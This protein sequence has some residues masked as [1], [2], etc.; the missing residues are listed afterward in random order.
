V[1]ENTTTDDISEASESGDPARGPFEDLAQFL[2]IPRVT[3]LALAPDGSRLVVGVQN[4]SADKKKFTSSIWQVDPDGGEPVRLTRSAAGESAP[5]FLPDGS[6]LFVAKRPDP[7]A[8]EGDKEDGR[9]LWLLPKHGGEARL[10][11]APPGGIS[12]VAIARET[13][14]VVVST[15]VMPRAAGLEEDAALRKARKDAAVSAILHT[16]AQ[17]REWD[18]QLGPD[19]VRLFAAD[20]PGPDGKLD[21]RDLT[22]DIGPGVGRFDV[23]PDGSTVVY[24]LEVEEEHS[25]HRGELVALDVA[26]GKRS[27][28]ARA[29]DADFFAPRVSPDGRWVA[30][31]RSQQSDYEHAPRLTIWLLPVGGGP[32][33]DL[34]PGLDLWP[35][36]AG[37]SPDASK[38]YFTADQLG[39]APLFQ[40]DVASGEVTRLTGDRASYTDV[41]VAPDGTLFALRSWIDAPPRPVRLDPTMVD[42]EPVLLSAPGDT[43]ELPGRLEEVTS[44]GADGVTVHS[45]LVLPSDV[46]GPA[47]LLLVIHGGPMM[48]NNSW[49]WRW[50]PWTLAARGYAALI[51]DYALSTGYGQA[52]IDRGKGERSGAPY[53]DLM[54]AVDAVIERPDIDGT[55][56]AAMGGSFGGYLTNWIATQTDR[57][58]ALVSHAG[59]WNAALRTITD[60]PWYFR[61]DYGDVLTEPEKALRW[62]PHLYADNVRTPMLVTHGNN[63]YRVPVA[64]ALWQWQDLKVRG[65]DAKFLYFPDENHWILKPQQWALWTE[66]ILAFLDEKVLGKEWQQ[67]ELL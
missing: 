8:G 1:T 60:V 28:F 31:I 14:S 26:S 52:F 21:L 34:T 51:P 6:L 3:G 29:D 33:R 36:P 18:E 67:P 37:W 5:A 42:Q 12:G 40:V 39:R 19:T 64:N 30:C 57:F 2:K 15:R 20:A 35:D 47:P 53:T 13:G 4:L 45:R 9:G 58:S 16:A 23:T 17:V 63:D 32:G 61:R 38:V 7:D 43:L 46:A 48:S 22:G 49:S 25:E 65:V 54:A 10:L 27:T 59:V 11:A 50:N 24:D 56:T 66:T 44:Q 62:S 41:Q 55:R